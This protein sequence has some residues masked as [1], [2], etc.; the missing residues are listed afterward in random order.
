MVHINTHSAGKARQ[1][2]EEPPF[3][4]PA[5]GRRTVPGWLAELCPAR[6]PAAGLGRREGQRRRFASFFC[7]RP[8]A[9]WAAQG[10]YFGGG[11]TLALLLLLLLLFFVT[12]EP[13][14]LIGSPHWAAKIEINH[15]ELPFH[16]AHQKKRFSPPP[17]LHQENTFLSLTPPPKKNRSNT[18]DAN[19]IIPAGGPS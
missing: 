13:L 8:A 18:N 14:Q 11:V 12:N 2:L 7:F 6:A 10:D 1:L 5:S 15:S 4:A 3:H 19:L 17:P 9:L 16:H